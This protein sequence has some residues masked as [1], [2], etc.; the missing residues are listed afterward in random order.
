M[1]TGTGADSGGGSRGSSGTTNVPIEYCSDRQFVTAAL[2]NGWFSITSSSADSSVPVLPKEMIVIIGRYLFLVPYHWASCS[3]H[4]QDLKL[5]PL[6]DPLVAQSLPACRF[7]WT[8]QTIGCGLT[9]PS[10]AV[11]IQL[12]VPPPVGGGQALEAV[13]VPRFAVGFCAQRAPQAVWSR[14]I[15][16]KVIQFRN[17]TIV[18]DQPLLLP[19]GRYQIT[20]NEDEKDRAFAAPRYLTPASTTVNAHYCIDLSTRSYALTLG[21]GFEWSVGRGGGGV[22]VRFWVDN[23][24]L[25]VSDQLGRPAAWR[26]WQKHPSDFGCRQRSGEQFTMRLAAH[27]IRNAVPVCIANGDGVVFTILPDWIPPPP[28]VGRWTPDRDGGGK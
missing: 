14:D 16:T 17:T 20:V 28:V 22:D 18:K 25:L 24:P 27:D 7:L 8:S 23:Q 4:D 2:L 9:R 19:I 13:R 11:T 15:R 10:F 12:P 5:T 6:T 3:R 26:G 21:M 1:S